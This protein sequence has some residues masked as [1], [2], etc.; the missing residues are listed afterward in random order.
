METYKIRPPESACAVCKRPFDSGQTIAS[1]IREQEEQFVRLDS[2]T[3]CAVEGE[4]FCRF[5]TRAPVRE[6][7]ARTIREQVQEFFAKLAALAERTPHQQRLMYLSALWL[8]RK[9]ALKLVETRRVEGRSILVLQRPGQ[10]APLELPEELI[11]E[12]ELPPLLTELGELF[13]VSSQEI[14]G[15][16]SEAARKT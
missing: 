14:G 16:P 1:T 13:H 4:T 12:E 15:A 6:V 11:P 10:E 3:G 2:C 8:T 9:K 7:S 5:T